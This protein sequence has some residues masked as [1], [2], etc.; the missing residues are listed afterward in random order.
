MAIILLSAA[1]AVLYR[2]GGIGGG[3][4]YHDSKARD[5]GCSLCLVIALW[6]LGFH[7]WWLILVFGLQFGSLT[8]YNKWADRI[9]FKMTNV[10]FLGWFFTGLSYSLYILPI[11]MSGQWH[12]AGFIIRTVVLTVSTCLWSQFIGKV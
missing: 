8:T 6:L 4:W 12:W 5:V 1:S 10:G 11:T 9:I 7:S 3:Q 2:L